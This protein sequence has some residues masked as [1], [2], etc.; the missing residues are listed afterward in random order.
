QVFADNG[1]TT[2]IFGKWHLGDNYPFRPQ[3]RGFQETLVHGGGG[4]GQI[5]DYWGNDYFDDTYFRNGQPEKFTGYCTD[6]FFREAVRFIESH[7]DQPFFVY[8]P[9]NAPHGPY[10]VGDEWSD[11]YKSQVGDD[12]ELA[13]FYG[14]IANIDDNVGRLR[15]RLE[16][17]GIADNTLLIFLTDNGTARGVTFTDY[18]GNEGRLVSGYNA[19]MRGRKGSPYQGGH[20]VPCFFHW[21]AAKLTGGRDVG[22]LSA[23]LDLLPTLVELCSLKDKPRAPGDGMSLRGALTGG[24]SIPADRTLFAHHQEL[25]HPEK[26]RFAS[27]MQD[28]WRLILRNDLETKPAVELYD[29][30]DDPGQSR[31]VAAK[32]PE[33]AGRL[34]AAYDAWWSELAK[35]FDRPAEIVVGD[36]RQNPSELSCFEWHSSQQWQQRAV[37]RGFE[38]NG[39]WAIRVAQAGK[40]LITLRRWP[41]EVDAPIAAGIDGGRAISVT[42]ARL[43]VAE[44]D[45]RQAVSPQAT[46]VEFEVSLP[47]GSTRLETWFATADGKSIGAYYVSVERLGER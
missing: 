15:T 22:G 40:Y 39:Y 46:V 6:V 20:R 34:R 36:E 44:F 33:V 8:L 43:R 25:H 3:D 32:H 13:R 29:M 27:V 38:G 2:A 16:K 19:G 24:A 14:M 1:Y 21:P 5:P 31:D 23:H 17:L 12:A 9:T 26:D 28:R 42:S 35:S 30:T 7:R 4:V 10:R 37:L 41:R 18:R 45:D 11:P 47:A